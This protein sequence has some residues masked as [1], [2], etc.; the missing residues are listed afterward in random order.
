MSQSVV[1]VTDSEGRRL[2][3]LRLNLERAGFT[4]SQTI[5]IRQGQL[6]SFARPRGRE[7]LIVV[8]DFS[9]DR[10]PR[11]LAHFVNS[12]RRQSITVITRNAA[13][14]VTLQMTLEGM[15]SDS[16]VVEAARVA[17]KIP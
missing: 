11:G 9:G 16:L 14:E 8:L 7:G 10:I 12:L 1:I 13:G 2:G 4:I 17:D 15:D 3:V 5:V 6:E